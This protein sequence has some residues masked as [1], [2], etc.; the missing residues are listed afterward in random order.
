MADSYIDGVLV[1]YGHVH[2]S[3]KLMA[4]TPLKELSQAYALQYRESLSKEW[5]LL[6]AHKKKTILRAIFTIVACVEVGTIAL[7]G[8]GL[9][10]YRS[11]W[12]LVRPESV[13]VAL[14]GVASLAVVLVHIVITTLRRIKFYNYVSNR[15]IST[16][17][18]SMILMRN[19]RIKFFC[20]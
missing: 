18:R 17:L 16:E 3:I 14:F 19:L 10:D 12:D 6:K 5:A 7:M 2:E 4:S 13:K 9:I 20:V 15:K 1:S 8:V 11:S